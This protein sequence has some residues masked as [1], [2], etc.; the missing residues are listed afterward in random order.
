MK[1]L[2]KEARISKAMK[3]TEVARLLDIDAAL[4]S[5]FESGQRIPT[6]PQLKALSELLEIDFNTIAVAW[7]QQKIINLVGEEPEAVKA[8]EAAISQLSGKNNDSDA[9]IPASFQRLMDEMESLKSI[10][11]HGSRGA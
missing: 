1:T 3:T 7:L 10:L 6:K 11:S 2:L 8:L 4:I 9:P 5:K